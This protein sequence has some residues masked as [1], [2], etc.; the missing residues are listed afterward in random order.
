MI[1]SSGAFPSTYVPG[2]EVLRRRTVVG[3]VV[4]VRRKYPGPHQVDQNA[5]ERMKPT[6]PT[7]IRITPTALMSTPEVV[8]LTAEVRI[9]PTAIRISLLR[10]PCRSLLLLVLPTMTAV[11]LFLLGADRHGQEDVI[12]AHGGL[13]RCRRLRDD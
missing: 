5:S 12:A 11:S 3:P 4:T 2:D 6:S 9:A 10:F 13:P 8:A 1:S 7:I